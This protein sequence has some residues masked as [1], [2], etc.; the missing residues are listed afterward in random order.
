[1]MRLLK[2]NASDIKKYVRLLCAVG[3]TSSHCFA[4]PV[5]VATNQPTEIVKQDLSILKDKIYEFLTIQTK[6]YPGEVT[7]ITG[8]IDPRLKLKPCADVSVFMPRGSRPWGR[9]SVGLKCMT[10]SPWTIYV[11]ASV[12]VDGQ[13]LVA[14]APLAQGQ[15]VTEQDVI[16]EK[17]D[18]TQ[19]PAGVY[20]EMSQAIGQIVNISMNAGTVLRKDLLKTTPVVQQGQSVMLVT[21]GNGFT[22]SAEGRAI[23]K[24]IEGQVVQVKVASG[25]VVSGIARQDG[26]VEVNY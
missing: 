13:Y 21:K 23:N 3:L 6:G 17:G 26:K 20:T 1:M 10:P 22:I 8:N 14:A 16:F 18:L 12:K 5:Q 7:I 11:Q 24:A 4:E 19:L 15:I 2:L 9:T 25:Q